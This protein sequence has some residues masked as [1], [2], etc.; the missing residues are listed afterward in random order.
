MAAKSLSSLPNPQSL[1]LSQNSSLSFALLFPLINSP[2]DLNLTPLDPKL[3]NTKDPF[4]LQFETIRRSIHLMPHILSSLSPPPSTFIHDVSLIS[5]IT[6][7]L[8]FPTY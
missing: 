2:L 8:C 4:W 7:S 5:P 1:S 3:V 6:E